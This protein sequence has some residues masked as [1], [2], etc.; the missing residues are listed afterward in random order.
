M[1]HHVVDLFSGSDS[2]VCETGCVICGRINKKPYSAALWGSKNKKGVLPQKSPAFK[3]KSAASNG[4]AAL[5]DT[6]Q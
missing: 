2:E 1:K 4:L 6:K 3:F 5:I